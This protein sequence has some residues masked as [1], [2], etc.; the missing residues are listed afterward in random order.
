MPGRG[1]YAAGRGNPAA[2]FERCGGSVGSII[3]AENCGRRG[4]WAKSSCSGRSA[5]PCPPTSWRPIAPSGLTL[6]LLGDYGAAL[7]HCTQGMALIDLT[8]QRVQRASHALADGVVC[9][10]TAAHVLWYLGF[11]AQAVQ[12]SQESLALAQALE[13]PLVW[14]PLRSKRLACIAAVGRCRGA[15]AGRRPPDAG[16]GAGVSAM[17]GAGLFWRGYALAMQGQGEAGLAQMRQGLAA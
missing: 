10:F 15:G 4:S 9:L 2:L 6:C 12:R 3:T 5:P 17:V 8:Q 11:P 14:R 16:D 1:S 13:H 7:T